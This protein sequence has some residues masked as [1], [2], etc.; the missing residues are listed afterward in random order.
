MQFFRP[1]PSRQPH[2]FFSLHRQTIPANPVSSIF[3]IYPQSNHFFPPPLPS[4]LI[5][6]PFNSNQDYCKSKSLLIG[7][8]AYALMPLKSLLQ[9]ATRVKLLESKS[10]HVPLLLKTLSEQNPKSLLQS[11]RPFI[12]QLRAHFRSHHLPFSLLL[13]PIQGYL[14][15]RYSSDHTNHAILLPQD[16]CTCYFHCF[17]LFY[18]I[19]ISRTLSH[20]I[21]VCS[22]HFLNFPQTTFLK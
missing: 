4:T 21:Q 10:D 5:Q 11:T 15:P 14:H 3:K 16:F 6:A 22:S 13:I 20:F 19:D 7:P 18:F 8:L 12:I 17:E 1:K 9:K 2:S